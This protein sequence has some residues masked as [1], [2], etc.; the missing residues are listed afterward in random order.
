MVMVAF[1]TV[2]ASQGRGSWHCSEDT[3]FSKHLHDPICI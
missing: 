3:V 1:L 2:E